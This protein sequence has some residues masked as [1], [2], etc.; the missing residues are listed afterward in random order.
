VFVGI[1]IA[2]IAAM[3]AVASFV[4]VTRRRVAAC[5][6]CGAA[7]AIDVDN[8]SLQRPPGTKLVHMIEA[9]RCAGC[10]G[11]Y[12][13]LDRGPLVSLETWNAGTDFPQARIHR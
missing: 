10:G 11:E 5:P 4:W 1:Y 7:L 13:Q 9:Y 3:T 2:I 12:R 8:R 6:R